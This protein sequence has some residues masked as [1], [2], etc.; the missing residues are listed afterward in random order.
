MST[1]REAKPPMDPDTSEAD[2]KQLDFAREQGDAYGRALQHMTEVVAHDGGAQEA[3]DYIIG[4]AVEEAEGM[5]EL[6]DGQPVW[7]EPGDANMH[8]EVS[9]RDRSDGRFVP[10]AHV[11][12]S[13]IAPD[14]TDVVADELPL[15][16]H[17]MIYHY[18][19]NLTAPADGQYTLRVNVDPPQFMRHD[20]VNGKRF[21]EP[22]QVEFSGVNV[23]RGQ[24]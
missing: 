3:G 2:S 15:L 13:L 14:G 19:R 11:S 21:L 22:V 17:P 6:V 16:W 7:R 18:G 12:A 23:A 9:V 10:T 24:D 5:Y 4:Y 8:L 1:S 20:E